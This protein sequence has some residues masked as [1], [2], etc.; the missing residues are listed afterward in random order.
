[1]PPNHALVVQSN[2]SAS[3][4]CAS[5]THRSFRAMSSLSSTIFAALRTHWRAPPWAT[6]SVFI[7]GCQR[8]RAA[9]NRAGQAQMGFDDAR[10]TLQE[11][12]SDLAANRP[13]DA[14][15]QQL[16]AIES[17]VRDDAVARARFLR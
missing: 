14:V 13:A 1:M 16:R 4:A 6:R 5:R 15:L 10:A 7:N 9:C 2:R 3:K 8:D 11:C 17:A 12:L